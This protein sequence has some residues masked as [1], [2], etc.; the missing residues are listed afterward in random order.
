MSLV[1]AGAPDNLRSHFGHL[2]ESDVFDICERIKEIDKSLTVYLMPEASKKRFSIVE[3][4]ADGVERFVF[5]T[6][7]LD[8]RVLEKLRYLL[9]VPFIKRLDAA[10]KLEAKAEEDARNRKLD[11][12][13]ENMG[14]PMLRDLERCGFIQRPRSYSKRGMSFATQ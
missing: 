10:E 12:L 1:A 6:D 8:A 9:R 3:L 2:V 13:Y 14:A 4:C 5:N 11:D 7:E